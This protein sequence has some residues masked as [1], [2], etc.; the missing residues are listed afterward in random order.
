VQDRHTTDTDIVAI[1]NIDNTIVVG[2]KSFVYTCTGTSNDSYTMSAPGAKQ[3]CVAKRSMRFLDGVGVVF[4]SPDGWMACAGSAGVLTNLTEGVFSK[5]Q[6]EALD[7]SSIIAEV[8]DGILFWFSTGQTPDSGY[9]MDVRP[10]GFGL[11]SLSFHAN[12]LYADPLTD[13]LF[14]VLDAINEPVEAALPV[15]ST[16]PALGSSPFKTIYQFDAHATN[17]L[18]YQHRGKL[19]LT[20]Y[21]ATLG[22]GRVQAGDFTNLVMRTYGDGS[23]IQTKVVSDARAFPLPALAA[24]DS[25]E[26]EFVGTSRVRTGQLAEDVREFG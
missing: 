12:A 6:W 1:A 2:T 10:S 16:A 25:Y 8:H 20:P 5:Q 26:V 3:A 17:K 11:V 21:P 4:A 13:R 14:M 19:H 18:R 15:A 22:L 24:R 9:A 7:P 23:V